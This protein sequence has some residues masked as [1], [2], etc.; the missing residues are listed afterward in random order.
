MRTALLVAALFG[1]LI[2]AIA[3]GGYM[4]WSMYDVPIGINGLIAL[5]LGA[6]ASLAL[7]GGLMAL[8]FISSRH[9]HDDR[10]GRLD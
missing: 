10:Q 3:A 7:G 2:V 1:L 4:W 9:G 5:I 8:V 6:V